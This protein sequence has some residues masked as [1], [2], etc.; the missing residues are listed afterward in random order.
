M[1]PKSQHNDSFAG[2]E[3][4]PRSIANLSDTIVMPA[5]VQF[6]R[7]LCDRTVEIQ[8]VTVQRMLDGEICGLQSCGSANAAKEC[9]Q[10]QLP[11][12]ATNERDSRRIILLTSAVFER[13]SPL[14]S[15]LSPQAGRG[16]VLCAM[17]GL[18]SRRRRRFR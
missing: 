16:A 10:D 2:Q 15:V 5:T 6:D 8:D 18:E 11:S 17:F 13:E 9:A 4:R 3:F 1:I 12:F 7:E 14:T